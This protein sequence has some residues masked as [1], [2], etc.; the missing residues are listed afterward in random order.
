ML[1]RV[2]PCL[3]ACL[4]ASS[5]VYDCCLFACLFLRSFCIPLLVRVLSGLP[6]CWRV[7]AA[8]AASLPQMTLQSP[9]GSDAGG[10]PVATGLPGAP[11][12]GGNS[13]ELSCGCG[14][15]PGAAAADGAGH[16]ALESA[17]GAAALLLLLR[18]PSVVW[19]AAAGDG[20]D[21]SRLVAGMVGGGAVTPLAAAAA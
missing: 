9:A 6:A 2:A 20:V 11:G 13:S 14:A 12:F 4:L 21:A 16:G 15:S 10:L 7:A 1:A 3:C 18:C 5:L 8:A 17:S 19:S